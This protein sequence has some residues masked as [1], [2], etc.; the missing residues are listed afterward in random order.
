LADFLNTYEDIS[1]HLVFDDRF[2]ELVS[3]G[4]DLAIRIGDLPD[5]SLRARKLADA[6]VKLI[7]SP[8]YLEEH[9]EPITISDLSEHNLLHYSHL[10]SG[11]FWRL[12]SPGG[13]ER[14]V[15]AVGRLTVNNGDALLS[16]AENGLGVAFLP[17]FIVDASIAKGRVVEIMDHARRAPLGVFAV[18]PPGRYTQPKLRAFIDFLAERMKAEDGDQAASRP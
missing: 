16:A 4:Y 15:R 1:V 10:S 9:G 2:V 17:D 6:Q 18:Y 5:S 13:Q 14:Q 11:N 7:A 8:D 12:Q 3:E